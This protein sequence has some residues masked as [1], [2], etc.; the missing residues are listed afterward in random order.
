MTHGNRIGGSSGR[1]KGAGDAAT[2]QNF[3][4]PRIATARFSPNTLVSGLYGA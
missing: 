4:T 1:R 3:S 2:R